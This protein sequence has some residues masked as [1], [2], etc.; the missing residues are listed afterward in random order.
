MRERLRDRV[1]LTLV[2]LLAGLVLVEALFF[3]YDHPVFPWHFV[4]GYAAAIGFVFALLMVL[5]AK[6]LG[7]RF[8]QRPDRDE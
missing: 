3:P 1:T 8:L 4:P 2:A 5:V 7:T 6:T